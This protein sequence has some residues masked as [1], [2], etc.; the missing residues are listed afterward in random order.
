[1]DTTHTIRKAGRVL[2]IL[3]AIP[4][5]VGIFYIF[6]SDMEI[7]KIICMV[8]ILPLIVG[9]CLYVAADK[10]ITPATNKVYPE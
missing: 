10:C 8:C 2:T 7:G 4:I 6:V 1:M 5:I 3:F 9:G